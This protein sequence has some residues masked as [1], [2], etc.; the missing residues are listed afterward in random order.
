MGFFAKN[1]SRGL[2]VPALA[3]RRDET[4]DGDG[5]RSG[6][7][8]RRAAGDKKS[9]LKSEKKKRVGT[10]GIPGS[11]LGFRPAEGAKISAG[12][13]AARQRGALETGRAMG[14]GRETTPASVI[15]ATG[16][17]R[18]GPTSE[19]PCLPRASRRR[20]R[21]CFRRITVSINACG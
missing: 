11:A 9:A 21:A 1:A 12:G 19:E 13:G 7:T 10:R 17:A 8:S 2:P 4:G 16:Y 5:E 15:D 3:L 20:S 6:Q 14:T 18:D